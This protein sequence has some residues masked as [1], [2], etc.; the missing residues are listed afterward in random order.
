MRITH[1]FPAAFTFVE[2]LVAVVILSVAL[3]SLAASASLA[4]RQTADDDLTLRAA[5]KG[6]RYAEQTFALPC[7][8]GAIYDSTRGLRIAASITSSDANTQVDLA[9][10]NTTRY[11]RKTELYT[12]IGGCY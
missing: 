9:S 12:F 2:V 1:G 8:T 3:L 7:R 6:Q 10:T 5:T 4:L 11:G